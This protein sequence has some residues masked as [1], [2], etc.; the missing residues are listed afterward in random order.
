MFQRY[1]REFQKAKDEEARAGVIERFAK[2]AVSSG[3]SIGSYEDLLAA[4]GF[5]LMSLSARLGVCDE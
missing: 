4:G 2:A 5:I 3:S 1:A